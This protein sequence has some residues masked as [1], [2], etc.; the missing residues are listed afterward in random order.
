MN[1]STS[2]LARA[3]ASTRSVLAEVGPGRLG[4]PTPCASWDV[5]GVIDHMVGSAYWAAAAVGAGGESTE[6]AEVGVTTG[7]LLAGYDECAR[8]TLAAFGTEGVLRS[9]LRLPFGEF[10]G[11]ALMGLVAND[12]F[13][14]GWD[15]ARAIGLPTD[16]DPELAEELIARSREAVTES[17]R[18]ADGEAQFG[19]ELPA[20]P[21]AGPADRLAAFLG[22]KV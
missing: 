19:P 11:A 20:P 1:L 14:H 21:G 7:D 9:T 4:D 13:T 10:S 16:L 8:V 17:Y 18:G 12:Q 6:A 22:R 2:Q 15:L 3:F 5:R